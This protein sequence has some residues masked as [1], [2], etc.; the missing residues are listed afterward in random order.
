MKA[1][2]DLLPSYLVLLIGRVNGNSFLLVSTSAM[3]SSER[4]DEKSAWQIF[5]FCFVQHM[6]WLG[7]WSAN[8]A[9]V[10]W[11]EGGGWQYSW[12]IWQSFGTGPLLGFYTS[13]GQL[14]P[15]SSWVTL[16]CSVRPSVPLHCRGTDPTSLV[17]FSTIPV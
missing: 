16:T 13:A 1:K 17:F 11:T 4:Q 14:P 7:G 12:G 2:K 8:C 3:L 6:N 5:L 15:V 10:V 9:F